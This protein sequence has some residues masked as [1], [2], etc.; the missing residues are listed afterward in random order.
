MAVAVTAHGHVTNIV[1]NGVYYR[2]FLPNI[3]PYTQNPPKVMGWTAGN[4]DN[5]YIAPNNFQSP[6]IICHV[7]ATPGK[8]HVA[9]RAGDSISIQ[10]NTWPE[11]H[12]G[13]V[14]DYLAR[15][16]GT[17]ETADKNALKFFKIDGSGL[18]SGYNPG[19][20]A[21]DVLISNAASWLVKIP[22]DI[23]PG[24]YVLRHEI[25]ALH[26][27]HEINAA[28]AY[29]QCF[30]LE[31]SGTG[32]SQPQLRAA[33]QVKRYRYKHRHSSHPD[34]SCTYEFY[35]LDLDLGPIHKFNF[36]VSWRVLAVYHHLYTVRI[37]HASR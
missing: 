24:N 33:I 3:D 31:I 10:W 1:V 13:P 37:Y 25:I 17:C 15:C 29:P 32:T 11:S 6:D 5:G 14:I 7:S 27:A 23:A 12:H 20:W 2:N 19:Y 8:A 22:E 18:V 35:D 4:T 30:N 36:N 16:N 9:V 34:I 21:A 26:G 28:Q